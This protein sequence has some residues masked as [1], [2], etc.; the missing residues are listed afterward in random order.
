MAHIKSLILLLLCSLALA[1]KPA[2][3]PNIESLPTFGL[4]VDPPIGYTRI[5]EGGPNQAT[6]YALLNPRTGQPDAVLIIELALLN[7]QTIDQYARALAPKF[8]ATVGDKP[9]TLAG[10]KALR[11]TSTRTGPE[12]HLAHAIIAE[13]GG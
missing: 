5:P 4:S 11:L 2:T 6:R 7:N 8:S 13:H 1:Q 9:T 12:L 10:R 3:K